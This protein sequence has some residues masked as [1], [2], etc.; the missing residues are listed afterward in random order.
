MKT[1]H[2][3]GYNE[4]RID[5]IE[6]SLKTLEGGAISFSDQLG[7]FVVFAPHAYSSIARADWEDE[8]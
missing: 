1:W 3:Y 8:H 6:G 4:E 5:T 7:P 2:V